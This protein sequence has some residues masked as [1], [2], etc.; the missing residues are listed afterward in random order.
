MT[1][2][3]WS[4]EAWANTNP[5]Q[6]TG[7]LVFADDFNSYTIGQGLNGVTPPTSVNGAKWRDNVG[8]SCV[9][10]A[11]GRNG[12]NCLHFNFKAAD[13][14]SDGADYGHSW[15]E[16]KMEL[17][18]S[19]ETGL[20]EVWCEFWLNISSTS[21]AGN[22]NDKFFMLHNRYHQANGVHSDIYGNCALSWNSWGGDNNRYATYAPSNYSLPTP[23]AD[24]SVESWGHNHEDGGIPPYGNG[25]VGNS[26]TWR[27][28]WEKSANGNPAG[29]TLDAIQSSD[30]GVWVRHRFHFKANDIGVANG[31]LEW[32]RGNDLILSVPQIQQRWSDDYNKITGSYLLGYF[33]AG[34]TSPT[35]WKIDDIRI[36]SADPVWSFN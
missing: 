18:N 11:D 20:Q 24:S 31:T 9:V 13:D 30:A 7:G 6:V 17:C 12:G 23:G 32:W 35:T 3:A 1:V 19:A 25:Y 21:R 34:F 22:S 8:S 28:N 33:N 27:R 15:C 14:G 4:T 10:G 16:Q 5:Q 2:S 36:Y 29:A 26:S